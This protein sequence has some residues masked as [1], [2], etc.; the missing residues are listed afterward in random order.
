MS[1][2]LHFWCNNGNRNLKFGLI[3]CLVILWL[4][5]NVYKFLETGAAWLTL[6]FLRLDLPFSYLFRELS[7]SFSVLLSRGSGK[8]VIFS[9]TLC[10]FC[11]CWGWCCV[12]LRVGGVSLECLLTLK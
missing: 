7:L 5:M 12:C 1:V 2:L 6:L 11:F 9:L 4:P 8:C 3:R 10:V